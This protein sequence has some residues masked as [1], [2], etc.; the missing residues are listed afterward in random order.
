MA[1]TYTEFKQ[2]LRH[3]R[4]HLNEARMGLK[5]RERGLAGCPGSAAEWRSHVRNIEA[6]H[7]RLMAAHPEFMAEMEEEI[8]AW[9]RAREI[10]E[11]GQFGAGA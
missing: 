7:E 5:D 6:E 8:A 11:N 4:A 2:S 1:K 10:D 3:V 9:E